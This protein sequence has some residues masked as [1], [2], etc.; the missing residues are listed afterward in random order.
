MKSQQN[1]SLHPQSRAKSL[2]HAISGLKYVLL[3]EPNARLHVVA[4]A[5]VIVAGF[6]R[7]LMPMQWTA[8]AVAIGLVLITE[9][10]NTCVEKLCN[11]YCGGKW[12]PEV[13]V[14]KDISAGAVLI[15]AIISIIIAAFVFIL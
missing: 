10:L 4:T 3:H 2:L 9:T 8:I 7:H 13:K 1:K 6:I 5:C 15:A 11:L 14:I 12:H